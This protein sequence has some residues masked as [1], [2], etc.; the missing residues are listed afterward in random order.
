MSP[1]EAASVSPE[2]PDIPADTH[3]LAALRHAPDQGVAPPPG[4]SAHILSQAQQAVAPALAAPWLQ[5]WR[6]GLRALDRLL[7]QPALTG[8]L[9]TVALA[10]MIGVMW[11]GGAPVDSGPGLAEATLPATVPAASDPVAS[12]PVAR[13][14]Q[15]ADTTMIAA[16]PPPPAPATA[17]PARP[18]PPVRAP[19]APAAQPPQA[20]PAPPT[21]A[22][23][24]APA[25]DPPRRLE[26][27]RASNPAAVGVEQ[28]SPA[29]RPLAAVLDALRDQPATVQVLSV[30]GRNARAET[31]AG[32]RPEALPDAFRQRPATDELRAAAKA[33]QP[34]T[35]PGAGREWLAGVAR[36][37]EGRWQPMA[38]P[39]AAVG[40]P[41]QRVQVDGATA[42]RLLLTDSGVL[43]WP[44]NASG[45][46]WR[47]DLDAAT[48][49][50]LRTQAPRP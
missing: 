35:D 33:S 39:A 8:A 38:A 30:P 28:A 17:P 6:R 26:S 10:T 9:A 19:K 24:P 43:W 37:A 14:M 36:A 25:A 48:L 13:E 2:P 29:P 44:G 22:A 7:S 20:P 49:Q 15:A 41:G 5:R 1:H 3:L 46:A 11:R 47:A 12:D 23:E 31:R 40:E 45:P 4:L 34:F 42:G 32:A 16:V 50:I 21:A 18:K 27:A